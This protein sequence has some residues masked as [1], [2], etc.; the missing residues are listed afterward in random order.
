[1]SSSVE[2]AAGRC[3]FHQGVATPTRTRTDRSTSLATVAT[4]D[5]HVQAN[6][7]Y[8]LTFCSARVRC[9]P[10]FWCRWRVVT[11]SHTAA[12]LAEPLVGLALLAQGLHG[13]LKGAA[14]LLGLANQVSNS[15]GLRSAA[16]SGLCRCLAKSC[17]CTYYW[18]CTGVSSQSGWPQ[19]FLSRLCSAVHRVDLAG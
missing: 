14:H 15:A 19:A 5:R 3:C 12:E 13:C 11:G 7:T 16:P 18:W 9:Q 1:M 4:R 17:I 6:P 10:G 2:E 8:R